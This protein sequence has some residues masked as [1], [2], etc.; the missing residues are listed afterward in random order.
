MGRKV[1]RLDRDAAQVGT[2]RCQRPVEEIN[3]KSSETVRIWKTYIDI[4]VPVHCPGSC[5]Q[6]CVVVLLSIDSYH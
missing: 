1:G 4:C 6:Y 2:R 3:I 5:V